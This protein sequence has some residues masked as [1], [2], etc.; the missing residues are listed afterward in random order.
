VR[1]IKRASVLGVWIE[2]CRFSADTLFDFLRMP[3]QDQGIAIV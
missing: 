3:N 1:S 2:S